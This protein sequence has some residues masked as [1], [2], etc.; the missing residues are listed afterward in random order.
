MRIAIP[1]DLCFSEWTCKTCFIARAPTTATIPT[2]NGSTPP[3]ALSPTPDAAYP[4]RSSSSHIP[5]ASVFSRSP[6][7]SP[8]TSQCSA[9]SASSLTHT[10]IQF[11]TRLFDKKTVHQRMSH[12]NDLLPN[13]PLPPPRPHCKAFAPS[14]AVET[15][16][17]PA[18]KPPFPPCSTASTAI[19][20]VSVFSAYFQD[21][22]YFYWSRGIRHRGS[23]WISDEERHITIIE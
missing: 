11:S 4:L 21:T 10:S 20:P 23:K 18:F 2:S 15:G 1:A 8:S 14:G 12:P 19:Y 9:Y 6:V 3:I 16:P 7:V 17:C 13:L 22:V 5:Y